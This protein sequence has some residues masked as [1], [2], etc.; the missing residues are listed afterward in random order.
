MYIRIIKR[1][2]YFKLMLK[3]IMFYTFICHF[4]EKHVSKLNGVHYL[5][6]HSFL[7]E[8]TIGWWKAKYGRIT[9][10]LNSR[11]VPVRFAADN[12][13]RC[14]TAAAHRHT[15]CSITTIPHRY[16]ESYKSNLS[17]NYQCIKVTSNTDTMACINNEVII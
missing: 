2:W 16:P 17:I 13:K 10:N 4:E 11:S 1:V 14:G 6:W 7:L 12:N 9:L 5:S 8:V 3:V 15:D